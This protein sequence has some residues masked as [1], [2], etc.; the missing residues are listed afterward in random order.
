MH[1]ASPADDDAS[2]T[3][4]ASWSKDDDASPYGHASPPDDDDAGPNDERA[5]PSFDDPSL[6]FDD[7]QPRTQ[8]S[9]HVTTN[10]RPHRSIAV[11]LLPKTVPAVVTYAQSVVTA[12]TGNPSFPSPVPALAALA[13]AITALQSA[14]SAVLARTKGMAEVRNDKRAEL[15][16]LLQQ[17]RGYIQSVADA[18]YETA[19][20]VIRSAGIAVKKAPPPRVRTFAANQG[21]VSGS[22][23]LVAA[24][25][26]RH[27]SYEWQYSTDGGKTW[28]AAPA[29]IHAKTSVSGFTPGATVLFR[30]RPVT[31]AGEGDWSQTV[32]LIVK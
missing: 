25:A 28:I 31:I 8:R 3:D 30:Y 29:T 4:D 11:L 27:A 16:T 17:L 2:L 1:D 23:S 15:V 7:T 10:T 26:G 12:M 21:A 24:S 22:A 32:L 14:E 20:T 19:A 9:F 6:D 18:D 13:A 5:S